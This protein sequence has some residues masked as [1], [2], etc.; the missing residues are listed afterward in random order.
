M[1]D[2]LSTQLYIDSSDR[3]N[4]LGVIAEAFT[5]YTLTRLYHCARN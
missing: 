2:Y 3:F 4:P 5:Q 1:K